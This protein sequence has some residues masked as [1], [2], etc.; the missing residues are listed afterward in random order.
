M[1]FEWNEQ[2]LTNPDHRVRFETLLKTA[3]PYRAVFL[4]H[5]NF[6]V[7]PSQEID[8]FFALTQ[9]YSRLTFIIAHAAGE[10]MTILGTLG[11]ELE[12]PDSYDNIYTEVS[13][14]FMQPPEKFVK[15]LH[16]FGI[17]RVLFGT[18]Y[19]LYSSRNTLENFMKL[20]LKDREKFLV[21]YQN[22][23]DLLKK[24]VKNKP[25]LR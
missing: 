16:A 2:T 18:D 8:E 10:H 5:M 1:H 14:F 23:A 21:L 22:G 19:P 3:E 7:N 17:R 4:I 11:K 25:A 6:D 20:P 13:A 24:I 15:T 9:K 12:N